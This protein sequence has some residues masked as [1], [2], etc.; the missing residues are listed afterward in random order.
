[1]WI[2]ALCIHWP[3]L[4]AGAAQAKVMEKIYEGDIAGHI[5]V[6]IKALGNAILPTLMKVPE[7]L[8]SAKPLYK[9]DY[10]KY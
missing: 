10:S 3:S 5:L 4:E 6:I 7:D 2:D 1:M 8:V 9:R